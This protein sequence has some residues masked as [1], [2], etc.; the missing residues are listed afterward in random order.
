MSDRRHT[1]GGDDRTQ[2]LKLRAALRDP[3]TGLYAYSLYFDRIRAMLTERQRIG[4]LWV[5]LGERRIVESIYGWS[6]YDD[7]VARTAA[8]I[9]A[10]IEGL[11]TP[12]ALVASAGVHADAFAVFVPSIADGRE[13]TASTMNELAERFRIGVESQL[14]DD[15]RERSPTG[16]GTRVGSALLVD[17][18]FH[19]FERRVQ[20][21]LDEAR[22]L[23]ERPGEAERLAWI[24]E[25]QRVVR[26][27][28]VR[29]LFQSIV[30]LKTGRR[31]AV[32]AYARGPGG[33]A[34]RF[35]R[36]MFSLGRQAGLSVE[37]DRLC[38]SR[39]IAELARGRE[40]DGE[41][42]VFLNT[43]AENLSDEQWL[44]P[45]TEAA[46]ARAG[47]ARDR[48]VLECSERQIAAED[49]GSL[50]A[51]G[52]LRAAGYR[53]SLDDLGTGA[54]SLM[55][56]ERLRP[57]FVK[58]DV[59]LVRDLGENRLS[60]ELV[61]GL[62]EL[63]ERAGARLVAE[64]VETEA[65]RSALGECGVEWGQGWLFGRERPLPLARVGPS[66]AP[67]EDA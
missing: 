34:L 56:I 18:P 64:R 28:D 36:V 37:L 22:R 14:D 41:A 6:V 47:L 55:L 50:D 51:L 49:G 33:S 52:R 58:F 1:P 66:T 67:A 27:R 7:L 53:L 11:L 12:E 20:Q 32:E 25:L 21:A 10:Q 42:L 48:V 9:E 4:V 16:G 19:R 29:T 8:A 30:E 38:R 35:P 17:N 43:A 2:F 60:R 15:A 24:G 59:G 46:L 39:A 57:E 54:R 40:N 23:A 61:R 5:E 63:A 62:A 44:A 13:V 31:V 3:T 45:E 65:Q 26:D